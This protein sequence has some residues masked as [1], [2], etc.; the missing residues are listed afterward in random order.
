MRL[1]GAE[2]EYRLEE[3]V[4]LESRPGLDDG[5]RSAP[6]TINQ[7]DFL[8]GTAATRY[9]WSSAPVRRASATCSAP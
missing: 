3:T 8:L 7:I 6:L 9:A 2:R 5:R 4:V 1:L